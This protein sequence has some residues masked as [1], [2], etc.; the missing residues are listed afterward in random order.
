MNRAQLI[1]ILIKSTLCLALML[2]VKVASAIVIASDNAADPAYA[3]VADGAWT[4]DYLPTDIHTAGQNPEGTDNGG[5]G[6]GIWN[7]TGPHT[8]D[9]G[10][11]NPVPPY[12]NLNHFIDG[13]DFPTTIYNNLGA[14]AFGLGNCNPGSHCYG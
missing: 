2:V 6:F 14:P 1:T 10:Y 3:F 8:V 9:G 7:F 11:Q 12:G 13:V 4:G 5:T